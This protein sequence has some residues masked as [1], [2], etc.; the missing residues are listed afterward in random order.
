[1][2]THRLV[3]PC[4]LDEKIDGWLDARAIQDL[5]NSRTESCEAVIDLHYSRE[6]AS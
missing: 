5:H 1:M 3:C 2:T 4:G 6:A